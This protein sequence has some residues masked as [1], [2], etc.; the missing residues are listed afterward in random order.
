M[1]IAELQQKVM[2]QAKDKQWGVLPEEI[3]TLEKLA[4]IHSEVSEV[5]HVFRH[6]NIKGRDEFREELVYIIMRV[7]H[8]AGT[9]NVNIE[10]E[11]LKKIEINKTRNWK[12]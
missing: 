11:M 10:E 9:Y 1:H 7:L 2:G 5:L 6:N 12:K 8:L 3:N 4:L